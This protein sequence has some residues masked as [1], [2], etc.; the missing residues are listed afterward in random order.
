[1]SESEFK[2]FIERTFSCL[3]F[4]SQTFK[5]SLKQDR[6]GKKRKLSFFFIFYLSIILAV[7]LW[8][9]V[10]YPEVLYYGVS[11]SDFRRD[12]PTLLSPNL[13]VFLLLLMGMSVINQFLFQ[14]LFIG[15]LSYKMNTKLNPRESEDSRSIKDYLAFYAHSF[16][17]FLFFIPLITIWLFFFERLIFM[18]PIFPFVD[19]TLPNITLLSLFTLI[20]VWKYFI[21]IQL[22]REYFGTTWL[23]A[24]IPVIL[25][26]MILLGVVFSLYLITTIFADAILGGVMI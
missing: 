26:I 21:E 12:M 15:A 1:M 16:T 19:L 9:F 13:F 24:A 18:K 14:F 20:Y 22:N 5:D 6:D 3:F 7:A 10:A 8:F 4:P 11:G 23:K 2:T 17:S 25:Q